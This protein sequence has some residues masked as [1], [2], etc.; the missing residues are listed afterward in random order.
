MT[1][2]NDLVSQLLA[3]SASVHAEYAPDDLQLYQQL[4]HQL[5]QASRNQPQHALM[6]LWHRLEQLRNKYGGMPPQQLTAVAEA[7]GA[8]CTKVTGQMS[9]TRKDKKY[10]RCV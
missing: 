6:R 4:V 7:A 9:S 3:E 5:Q 8:R 10:M 2:F 1:L